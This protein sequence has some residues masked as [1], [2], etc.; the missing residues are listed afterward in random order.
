MTSTETLHRNEYHPECE[1]QPR[2]GPGWILTP[3]NSLKALIMLIWKKTHVRNIVVPILNLQKKAE[4]SGVSL[5]PGQQT[6]LIRFELQC[7][8]REAGGSKH[9]PHGVELWQDAVAKQSVAANSQVNPSLAPRPP[10][11]YMATNEAK[12][13]IGWQLKDQGKI[14]VAAGGVSSPCSRMRL[15]PPVQAV[16][17][18]NSL[19]PCPWQSTQGLPQ[20]RTLKL[21]YW[22]KIKKNKTKQ[23]NMKNSYIQILFYPFPLFFRRKSLLWRLEMT[24][25]ILTR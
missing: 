2:S 19:P 22:L 14:N 18:W 7:A 13:L 17:A 3:I 11:I 9:W 5:C 1:P 16:R 23:L 12:P 10:Q 6:Y 24:H 25:T 4:T 20:P 15:R 21:C 8:G